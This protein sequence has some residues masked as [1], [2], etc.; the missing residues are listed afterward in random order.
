METVGGSMVSTLRRMGLSGSARESPMVTEGTPAK[1][2]SSPASTAGTSVRSSPSKTNS[3]WTCPR[4]CL[5]SAGQDR[6]RVAGPDPASQE[7]A[8]ADASD[9]VVMAD[10]G[11]QGRERALGIV[12]RGRHMLQDGPEERGQVLRRLGQVR[13]RRA[14][15]ARRVDDREIPLLVVGVEL[16]EEVDGLVED[17]LDP[18]VRAVDLVDDDDGPQ[19]QLQGLLEHETGLRQRAF[20]RVDEQQDAVD[21]PEDAFHLAAEVR[22]AGRVDDVDLDALPD[23]R[24]VL[25]DDGDAPLALEIARIEDAVAHLVD[26]AEQLALPHHR[27]DQRRFAVIDVGDDADVADILSA[28]RAPLGFEFSVRGKI[29]RGKREERLLYTPPQ[30]RGLLRVEKGRRYARGQVRWLCRLS[31][32]QRSCIHGI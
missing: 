13:C 24:H 6:D 29:T 23:E 9:I 16:D 21:H 14:V 12:F 4:T 17:L 11:D 31:C 15:P 22:V 27:V 26:I 18:G 2:K 3:F 8:D 30:A 7:A 5:S 10:V 25:G 1:A 28:H 20:R 32:R 19:A